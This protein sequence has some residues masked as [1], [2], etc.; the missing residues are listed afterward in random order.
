L[1]V[2]SQRLLGGVDGWREEEEGADGEKEKRGQ[3]KSFNLDFNRTPLARVPP[4]NPRAN[5]ERS[6]KRKCLKS[7]FFL[8][9]SRGRL[10]NSFEVYD[11][12][13]ILVSQVEL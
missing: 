1:G 8:T 4:P 2:Q 6:E 7:A 11:S 13:L 10:K 9:A 3:K 12:H 5:L